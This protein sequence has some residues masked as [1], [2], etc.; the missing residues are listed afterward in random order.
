[1]RRETIVTICPGADSVGVNL[2][3]LPAT[4]LHSSLSE[5]LR[6]SDLPR[7]PHSLQT[8]MYANSTP[9]NFIKC[10]SCCLPPGPTSNHSLACLSTT[11]HLRSGA[12]QNQLL[13]AMFQRTRSLRVLSANAWGE[14]VVTRVFAVRCEKEHFTF[15]PSSPS[16]LSLS[17]PCDA[18]LSTSSSACV[19]QEGG[20]VNHSVTQGNQST[21]LH[22]S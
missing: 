5:C 4:M 22:P 18:F 2:R 21:L 19:F 6:G 10:F 7:H 13:G 11:E 17:S 14:G 16:S 20:L 1:M 12:T 3:G 9:N 8:P 15:S